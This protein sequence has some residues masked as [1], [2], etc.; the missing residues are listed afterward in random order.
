MFLFTDLLCSFYTEF[1]HTRTHSL[2]QV[3]EGGQPTTVIL[4]MQM[5]QQ[6]P[7]V[8][9]MS[10]SSAAAQLQLQVLIRLH[11]NSLMSGFLSLKE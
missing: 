3:G 6:F 1:T 11:H 9:K 10:T 4:Q 5:E 2:M 7:S 8:A